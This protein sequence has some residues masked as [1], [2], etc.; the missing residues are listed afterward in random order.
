M[1]EYIII[2]IIII[3]IFGSGGFDAIEENIRHLPEVVY[4]TKDMIIC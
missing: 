2:I 1:Y 3:I 4:G